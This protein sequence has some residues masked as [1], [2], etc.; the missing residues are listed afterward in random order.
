[1]KRVSGIYQIQNIITSK[2]YIGSSVNIRGR[3]NQHL[4]TLRKG[5]HHSR[6]L[7]NA[8]D[9]YGEKSF[10]FSVIELVVDVSLLVQREQYYLDSIRPYDREVGYNCSPTAESSRGAVRRPVSQETRAKLS[11]MNKGRVILWNEKISRAKKGKPQTAPNANRRPIK[12]IN[13]QTKEEI[14]FES[15]HDA[16]RFLNNLKCYSRIHQVCKGKRAQVHGYTFCYLDDK[17]AVAAN[18]MIGSHRY[19]HTG[20]H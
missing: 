4:H 14:R 6:H 13:L 9:K 20:S 10:I 17:E 5:R 12:A 3:W 7:Q 11:Q 19:E 18:E 8:W 2:V 16:A 15:A 1:M